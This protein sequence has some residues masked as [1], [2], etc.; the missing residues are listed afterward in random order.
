MARNEFDRERDLE[1]RERM[2]KEFQQTIAEDVPYI[3][4]DYKDVLETYNKRFTGWVPRY[5]SQSYKY[6]PNGYLNSEGGSLLNLQTLV[7]IKPAPQSSWELSLYVPDKVNGGEDVKIDAYL[8]NKYTNEPIPNVEISFE[9]PAEG[10]LS[11]RTAVTDAGG[12]AVVVFTAP[13]PYPNTTVSLT[14]KA[15]AYDQNA[16]SVVRVLKSLTVIPPPPPDID[17]RIEFH[18]RPLLTLEDNQTYT[19]EV[20]VLNAK[21]G[22]YYGEGSYGED[23]ALLK[24]KVFPD[25]AMIKTRYENGTWY[26]NFTGHGYGEYTVYDVQ[27]NAMFYMHSE[28]IS[29]AQSNMSVLVL[30]ERGANITSP[31]AASE[32]TDEY[33][34]LGG[35]LV[36]IVLISAFVLLR[37]RRKKREG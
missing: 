33:Y 22:E 21:T 32:N 7:N 10:T 17:L 29:T 3:V 20:R 16:D 31:P 37:K 35:A 23:R 18:P 12:K 36:A 15:S 4:M 2:C 8:Y 30:G 27:F 13:V 11:S 5:L 9:V 6:F 14:L 1:E 26:V 34:I 19:V 25:D 28:L 24:W